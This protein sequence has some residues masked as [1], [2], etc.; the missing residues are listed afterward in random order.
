MNNLTDIESRLLKQVPLAQY[1]TLGIGGPAEYYIE[2]TD[3]DTLKR[4]IAW[5]AVRGIPFF[6]IGGGSNIVVS[7]R[8]YPGLVLHMSIRGIE[9]RLEGDQ[10]LLRAGTGERW[11]S[12]VEMCVYKGWPGL[13]CLSGI[14][15]S[16]GA[17]PIQNIGAYGI[18]LKDWI[19]TIEALDI[20]TI[21][22]TSIKSSECD[23]GYRA[24]R[25][26]SD[27]MGRYLITALTLRLSMGVIHE[28]KYGELQQYLNDRG[29]LNPSPSQIREAVLSI[30]RGKSMVVD[31]QD[32]D[33]HSAGSFFVNPVVTK[34]EYENIRRGAPDDRGES[35]RMP[36]FEIDDGRIKLSA[37]WL[38][39][40]AGFYR[41]YVHGNVG[42]SSKH[43]L[44][45]INRGGG[46]AKE[47][48]ELADKIQK[49]V[50]D[51]FG[52]E[53]IPEPVF[54]GSE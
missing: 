5:A 20:R 34:T 50:K 7:D 9:T 54:V 27:W 12:I 17:A 15:G 42:L 19:D 8:G 1:T 51:T 47:V 31:A 3:V 2:V 25:F 29:L 36:A 23:F 30:R 52:I 11:D 14:P 45:I 28:V 18:E 53:L 40:R 48:M 10:V 35:H 13:E 44:A 41:G 37:A 33:S 49:A 32:I 46:T 4:S 24:S 43:S 39:E 38:I 22:M 21:E 6:T 26:K 16:A